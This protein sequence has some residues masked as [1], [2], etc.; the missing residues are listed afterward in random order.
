MYIIEHVLHV[1]LLKLM[2]HV[3]MGGVGGYIVRTSALS[4]RQGMFET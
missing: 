2:T 3:D 1:M 4:V